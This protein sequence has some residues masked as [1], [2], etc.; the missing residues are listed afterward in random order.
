LEWELLIG[1]CGRF[2]E[3]ELERGWKVCGPELMSNC[4]TRSLPGTRPWGWWRYEL[5]E[6]RPDE[7]ALRLAE[8]G[9]LR[10]DEI[11]AI[12]QRANEGRARIGTTAEHHDGQGHSADRDAVELYEAVKLAL[13][14]AGSE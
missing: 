11:T 8:H 1:P 5:C 13:R 2:T 6:E 9:L 4:A 12:T 10:D 7:P 3:A 14:E